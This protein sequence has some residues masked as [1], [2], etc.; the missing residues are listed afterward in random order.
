[1]AGQTREAGSLFI[2]VARNSHWAPA[3]YGYLGACFYYEQAFRVLCLA[4]KDFKSLSVAL[5]GKHPDDEAK[6]L[7]RQSLAWFKLIP[8]LLKKRAAFPPEKFALHRSAE[9]FAYCNKYLA[10]SGPS[11]TNGP[12][13]THSNTS[14]SSSS[15]ASKSAPA[16]V[17]VTLEGLSEDVILKLCSALF[18]PSWE[19]AY[20]WNGFFQIEDK[21]QWRRELEQS[22][23]FFFKTKK[24][25]DPLVFS[26][27]Q[28]MYRLFRGAMLREERRFTEANA[29]LALLVPN[30]EFQDSTLPE[31]W[32]IEFAKYERGLCFWELGDKKQASAWWNSVKDS[33]HALDAR[34]KFRVKSA[35]RKSTS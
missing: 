23:E 14:S 32:T 24:L 21:Q 1:L 26:G 9:L 10:S 27:Y 6:S 3:F 4:S 7:L 12:S 34:L 30:M 13:S 22:Y 20:F 5:N 11:S 25:E 33:G 17:D 15:S 31:R 16:P 18:W 19:L 28:A 8:S 2:T 29:E 35:L